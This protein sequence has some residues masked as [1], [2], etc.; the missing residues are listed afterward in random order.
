MNT[1]LILDGKTLAKSIEKELAVRVQ[2]IKDKSG[3]TPILAT[4]IVGNNPASVTYIRKKG[5]ACARIGMQSLKVEMPE[6]ST[7]QQVIDGSG[8]EP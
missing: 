5:N 3:V 4:I 1:P 6:D 7:T 8:T 2:R